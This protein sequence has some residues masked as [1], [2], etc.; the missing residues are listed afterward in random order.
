[1]TS[2]AEKQVLFICIENACR[3]MMAEAMFNA[4]PPPGWRAISAGTRPA[5]HPN[6]RTGPMLTE[7]G[8]ALPD[9]AP[10]LLTPEMDDEARIRV[11][12]GC[13][14]DAA[15]P[16]HLK[17]HTVQDW[18]LPDPAKLDDDGFRRVRDQLA[19]LV[20]RLRLE[21]VVLERRASAVSERGTG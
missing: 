17:A 20:R 16:A 9:H 14:D 2:V 6:P 13:L 8:L 10:R 15:C 3:S 5:P 21:I 7:I 12:M 18:G 11:T 19:D 1:V 4:N